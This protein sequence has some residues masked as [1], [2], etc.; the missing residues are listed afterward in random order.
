MI[1]CPRCDSRCILTDGD[2]LTHCL[3]CGWE[4]GPVSLPFVRSRSLFRG[5]ATYS[6]TPEGRAALARGG[7]RSGETR[8]AKRVAR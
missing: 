8:R 6:I 5:K 4:P 2:G 7:R 3:L 1:V